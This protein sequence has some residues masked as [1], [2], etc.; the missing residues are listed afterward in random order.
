MKKSEMTVT[1][2]L[3]SYNEYEDIKERLSDLTSSLS[4]CFSPSMAGSDAFVTFDAQKAL[5]VCRKFI[6]YRYEKADIEIKV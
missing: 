3:Y 5:S 6:P 2:P 1:M 4:D